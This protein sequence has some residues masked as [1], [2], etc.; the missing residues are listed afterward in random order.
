MEQV[1]LAF[2]EEQHSEEKNLLTRI[3][4]VQGFSSKRKTKDGNQ[5]FSEVDQADSTNNAG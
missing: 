3:S 2:S 4:R 5:P 1:E